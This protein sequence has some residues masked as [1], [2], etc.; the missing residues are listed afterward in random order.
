MFGFKF[1]NV[2]VSCYAFSYDENTVFSTFD[3]T[4]AVLENSLVLGSVPAMWVKIASSW[5]AMIIYVWTLI[6]PACF[7]DRDFPN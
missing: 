3:G 4:P 2:V 7:P 1:Y 6:A 5:A